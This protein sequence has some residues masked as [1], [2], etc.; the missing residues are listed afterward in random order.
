MQF[1]RPGYP[2][3]GMF[4]DQETHLRPS[5]RMPH[6]RERLLQ[7]SARSRAVSAASA[8]DVDQVSAEGTQHNANP[9]EFEELSDIIK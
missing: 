1:V 9:M 5:A 4:M 6:D 2:A 8:Q 3:A 7:V